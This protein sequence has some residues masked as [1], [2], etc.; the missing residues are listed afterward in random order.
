VLDDVL[1]DEIPG[2]ELVQHHVGEEVQHGVAEREQ[3]QHAPPANEAMPAGELSQR[4]DQQ[5]YQ[6]HSQSPL[7]GDT[8]DFIDGFRPQRAGH[9]AVRQ[10]GRRAETGEKNQRLEAPEPSLRIRCAFTANRH[11]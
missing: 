10:H 6:Q 5:C 7:S 1:D 2:E 11:Q 8:G 4:R 9:G 3:P